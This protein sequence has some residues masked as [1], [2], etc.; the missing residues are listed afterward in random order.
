M[1]KMWPFSETE[2]GLS[3]GAGRVFTAPCIL[4]LGALG[5]QH[6]E[7]LQATLQR[8]H[9]KTGVFSTVLIQMRRRIVYTYIH[10]GM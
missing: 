4:A 8:S 2:M 7:K 3:S 5:S 1:P 9:R 6:L 10:T